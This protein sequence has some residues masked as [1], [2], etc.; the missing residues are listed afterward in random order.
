MLLL[1]EDE[2]VPT[3]EVTLE[4]VLDM[5]RQLPAEGRYTVFQMLHVEGDGWW[6]R[7]VTQGEQ[8]IRRVCNERGLDWERL[9]EEQREDL[10]DD[11]VHEE[12]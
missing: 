5:V 6:S 2:T 10:V 11:L 4:Q 9:T 12:R 3:L 1:Q 8:D 7:V